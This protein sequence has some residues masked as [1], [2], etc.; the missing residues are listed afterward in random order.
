M[1]KPGEATPRNGI[2]DALLQI[3]THQYHNIADDVAHSLISHL[4]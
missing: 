2:H 1:R 4:P 3:I